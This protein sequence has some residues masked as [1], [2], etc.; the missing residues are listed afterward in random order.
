[1][2]ERDSKAKKLSEL[3]NSLPESA[4]GQ[5]KKADELSGKELPILWSKSKKYAEEHECS[6]A[7]AVQAVQKK[8]PELHRSWLEGQRGGK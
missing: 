8:N 5:G 3:K 7:K 2:A 6:E 1:M 4:G